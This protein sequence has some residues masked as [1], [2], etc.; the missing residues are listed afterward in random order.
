[1]ANEASTRTGVTPLGSMCLKSTERSGRP[2]ALALWTKSW[3]RS[4]M[5]SA[6]MNRAEVV[7]VKQPMIAIIV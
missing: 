5:N 6:R 1:M 2:T 7:Q 4:F 3:L